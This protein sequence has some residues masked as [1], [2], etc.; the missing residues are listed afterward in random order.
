MIAASQ[1]NFDIPA[2]MKAARYHEVGGPFVIDEI[3]VPT[4]R[5]T[6]VLVRVEACGFVPN[7]INVVHHFARY[8]SLHVPQR[9]AIF[10]LD[11]AGYVVQ[12]GDQVHGFEVG[13]RVYVN[14]MRYCGSCRPCRMGK[15]AGCD[16]VT[17]AGYFGK[18]LKSPAM[19]EE[20]PYGGVAEYMTAPQYGLTKIPSDLSFEAASRFGYFGTGYAGLRKAG[21]DINTTLLI[22]GVSGT[23]GLGALLFALALG[24]PK[25]LGVG[26][27]PDL[28]ARVKALAPDRIETLS[29]KDGASIEDWAK[30]LTEGR[31]VDVVLDALPPGSPT[32]AFA[33]ALAVLARCGHHVNVGGVLEP[34]PIDFMKV[35][36]WGQ[37]LSGSFW[38]TTQQAQEMAAFIGRGMV[39]RNELEKKELWPCRAD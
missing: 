33:V 8:P 22:N 12:V 1:F 2:Q 23:L 13:D 32:E 31:G 14:P 34:V 11:P 6:D 3:D 37:S 39:G 18:G 35:M 19:F 28:L 5:P 16:Y 20:Y 26:R 38:F 27:N 7:F 24:A 25:I 17:L 15:F 9:P 21:V 36:D 10:G 4:P 29:T 30:S